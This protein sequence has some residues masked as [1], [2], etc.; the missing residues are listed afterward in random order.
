M[1]TYKVIAMDPEQ[2]GN[3]EVGDLLQEVPASM[4][5][6]FMNTRTGKILSF[7]GEPF[8]AY[9]VRL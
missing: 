9:Y 1:R 4:G 3:I 8:P 5:Y 2:M 6:A 7:M